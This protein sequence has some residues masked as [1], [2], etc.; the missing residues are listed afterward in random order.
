MILA[1]KLTLFNNNNENMGKVV[2]LVTTC[3]FI[4]LS[5]LACMEQKQR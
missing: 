2:T 1:C 5:D 3:Q 4:K